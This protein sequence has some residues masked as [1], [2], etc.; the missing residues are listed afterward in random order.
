MTISIGIPFYNA[1]PYLADAIRSV[2]AQTYQDWELILV[3]DGSTD[4]SLD[5]AYSINDSRVRVISDGENKKLAYRL[6][7]ITSLSQYNYIARMDADDLIS[8][9]RLKKELSILEK[10]SNIDLVSTGICSIS[11]D[12]IPVG[13]RIY[14]GNDNNITMKDV[15]LNRSGIVHASILGRKNWFLRNPYNIHTKISEDYELWINAFSKNDLKIKR[16][17]E[18]LYYYRE[19][20]TVTTKKLLAQYASKR[21]TIKNYGHLGFDHST[22]VSEITK[23]YLKGF[24]IK[25]LEYVNMSNLLIKRRNKKINDKDFINFKNEI[26]AIKN[27]K[28]Q[29]LD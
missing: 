9:H 17:P 12:N 7:Q 20:E 18:A 24:I 13:Y 4:R 19:G 15:L 8:P 26:Q 5:I 6:N 27:T 29:G 16:I 11:N 21:N 2:F 10:N 28:I 25:G 3:N 14:E 22:M 23:T 1:E